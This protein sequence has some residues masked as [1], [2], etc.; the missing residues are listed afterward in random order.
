M[1]SLFS[2]PSAPK[3]TPPAAQPAPKPSDKE[4]QEAQ[5][6]A[7]RRRQRARGFRATIIAQRGSDPNDSRLQQTLGS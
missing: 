4:V 6:E 3:L 1:T 5:A 7:L 2:N